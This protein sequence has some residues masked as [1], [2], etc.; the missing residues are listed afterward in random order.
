MNKKKWI[1]LSVLILIAIILLPL[2]IS[3]LLALI[4][5]LLL[6]G[7]VQ[8]MQKHMK[9]GRGL[10]VFS[11]FTGYVALLG[12]ISYFT[13]KV[14]FDQFVSFAKSLPQIIEDIYSNIIQ[15]T[16]TKWEQVQETIPNGVVQS[17]EESFTNGMKSFE[18]GVNGF[19]NSLLDFIAFLPGFMFEVLIYL[20]ALYLFS[21]ELPRLKKMIANSLTEKT[22][23]K[24]TLIL[25]ELNKAGIGFV[26]AQ[27]FLSALTFVMAFAGLSILGVPYTAVLSLLI[28]IVDILPILGTGS[29]LVPWA[30]YAFFQNDQA[31]SL[32]LVILFL[33]ITVVRRVI[34]PKIFS[35]SMGITPLAALISLFIGFKL[36]GFIGLFA[37]P[38]CVIVF[39]TLRKARVIRTDFKI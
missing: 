5:A 24:L 28:V 31:L 11:A 36:L 14:V 33:V 25:D 32:G 4:T 2:C 15:P 20:I 34:E 29:F 22:K 3:L 17:L 7:L 30:I 27:I 10:A 6:E 13:V 19:L 12:I 26:K 9:F 18:E 8:R 1:L 37:G 38:A 23:E 35:S 16:L 39:E 21:L